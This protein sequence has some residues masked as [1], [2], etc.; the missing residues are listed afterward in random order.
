MDVKSETA[1]KKSMA[2]FV[3]GMLTNTAGL[4]VLVGPLKGSRVVGAIRTVAR[5]VILGAWKAKLGI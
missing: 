4:C 2:C 1:Y 3:C 5:V